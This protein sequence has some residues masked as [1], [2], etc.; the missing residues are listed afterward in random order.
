MALWDSTAMR[1][2]R[3]M[4]KECADRFGHLGIE[5]VFDLA[6]GRLYGC[7]GDVKE[8]MEEHF[9]EAVAADHLFGLG[10]SRRT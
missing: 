7:F 9:G 1:A 4:T 2:T 3:G 6:G 5:D 8:S 10:R